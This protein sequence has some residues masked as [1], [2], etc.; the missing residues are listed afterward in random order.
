MPLQR[1]KPVP[2]LPLPNLNGLSD[3]HPVF[4][5]KATGEIFLD[6]ESYAA[7]L[8][9]LLSRTFQC[10]YSGKGHLDYFTA[11]QSEKQESKLVQERFP[12][13]LK[14]R[15]LGSVHGQVMS[16][17][18]K[19]VDLVYD[20]Y[21]ERYFVGEKVFVD[22]SGDKYYARIAKIFPPQSIRDQFQATLSAASTS[23]SPIISPD[24]YSSVV[25]KIGTNLD[26]DPKE[27]N[28]Q[29]PPQDYL[30]TV[31]L[32]DEEHKFEGSFMEV[33]QKTLSR[34]R[35]GFSK[36]IL[37]RYMRECVQREGSVSIPWTV[38]PSIGR[39]F[40]ILPIEADAGGGGVAAKRKKGGEESSAVMKKRKTD[41]G[42]TSRP[43]PAPSTEG[44]KKAIKYPIEDLDLDPMSIHDGRVLRR[45]KTE[46]P[47]LPPKPLPRRNLPV[48]NDNFDVFIETWNMLNTFSKPLALSPFTLDDYVG[49]LNH[50]SRAPGEECVLLAEIHAAL[51]NIIGTDL[52]RVLGSSSIMATMLAQGG[53]G[54]GG[55]GNT[56]IKKGTESRG[57]GG[58]ETPRAGTPAVEGE[59]VDE[60]EESTVDSK[61]TQQPELSPQEIFFGKLI[62][63]GIQYGKR[64]D[65]QAKL[66]AETKRVGWEQHLIGAICQR[67][68][69]YF[70][71]RFEEIMRH[72]FV[73]DPVM[74][75]EEVANGG[76]GEDVE[77]KN[78]KEKEEETKEDGPP[79][80]SQLTDVDQDDEEELSQD[81]PSPEDQYL[82]L[83][84]ED[85]LSII[86][87]LMTLVLGSKPVRAYMDEADA[88]LTGLRKQRADVNKERRALQE[89]KLNENKKGSKSSNGKS[90]TSPSLDSRKSPAPSIS[91]ASSP[92]IRNGGVD[93]DEDELLDSDRESSVAPSDAGSVATRQAQKEEKLSQKR[94]SKLAAN[95]GK[96]ASKGSTKGGKKVS[97][98]S[99]DEQIEENALEEEFVDI[100]F[101]RYQGV[102]KCR[103]IGKDRF[104]CRYWWFDG[105]GGME[106]SKAKD[107]GSRVPYS[108]GKIFVQGPNELDWQVVADSKAEGNDGPSKQQSLLERRIREE[109]VDKEEAL[110]GIGEWG[111]YETPEE[112]DSLLGW[113]NTKGTRELGLIKAINRW[114]D[115]IVAGSQERYKDLE[116]P[117]RPR[118]DP[119]V[120][121]T[122]RPSR[123]KAE[124]ELPSTYLGYRNELK[125]Y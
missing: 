108:T 72:L 44:P 84:L 39:A 27:A 28:L 13:E 111:Y 97:T 35:L 117:T 34:D 56:P 106:I 95:S 119:K 40:G 112:I 8:S 96:S 20:R 26:I 71:E 98:L 114:R 62:K 32:M 123:N 86:N 60:L 48:D 115:Y 6:Y 88:E 15:V 83:P 2:L 93:D 99:L 11:L 55:E 54:G 43:G 68:G 85:K 87:Y 105:I 49:A 113:L 37:K 12:N 77:M 16:R 63:R 121:S 74:K 25:H 22:L 9:F 53:G 75:E 76:D 66:K 91:R 80:S 67:G 10:E 118:Y 79:K 100:Q 116:N 78:Q 7:R 3:D 120:T 57:G 38:K 73:S 47:T 102:L 24:D 5:L 42:T 107:D 14:G 1:R 50:N 109:V 90:T 19:L 45:T 64:W 30:Y 94:L 92:S 59:E 103:P 29:D 18:D 70:L 51:T 81:G 89:R 23:I 17:L 4:Y 125:K 41:D 104:H 36:S 122:G 65:R 101:R 61:T 46:V 110:V 21:K 124:N 52:S 69:P 58:D 82:T 31:Q 33:K